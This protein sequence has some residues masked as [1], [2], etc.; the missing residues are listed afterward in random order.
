MAETMKVVGQLAMDF[1]YQD[2]KP[3]SAFLRLEHFAWLCVAA[4]GKLK[5]D[6]YNNQVMVNLRRRTPHAPVILGTDSYHSVEV[7]I[8]DSKA[9]LPTPIMQFPGANSNFGISQVTLDGNCGN[10][11][12]LTENE[13]W[14]VTKIKDVVF[15]FPVDCGIAFINLYENCNPTKVKVSYIQQ[16]NEK[17]I[18]AESRKWAIL[19]MVSIFVKSAKEGVV[20]DMSN[21]Q[22][23]NGILQ[24]EI[25]K[26]LLKAT[27]SNS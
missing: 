12:P 18:V 17:S 25:N 26:Y 24:T 22:N 21:D 7:P 13:K 14:Q 27:S 20:I 16:L 4:D 2:Y 9:V 8:K 11:M 19:N 10:V 15:W 23:Q 5:Q 1:F 6:E 3:A